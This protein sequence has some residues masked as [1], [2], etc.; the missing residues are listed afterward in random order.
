MIRD[1]PEESVKGDLP[2]PRTRLVFI[3]CPN[4]H[5]A[6]LFSA[7]LNNHSGIT[8]LGDTIPTRS[9]DVVCTC[10]EPVSRCGF[11]RGAYEAARLERYENEMFWMPRFPRLLK[12]GSHSGHPANKIANT[13]LL[14]LSLLL[15]GNLWKVRQAAAREFYENY[16]DFVDYVGK[17][18]G[19]PVFLEGRKQ[20]FLPFFIKSFSRGRVDVK[21]IHVIRNPVSFAVS[22][23]ER[24]K[25]PGG[26]KKTFLTWAREHLK[27]AAYTRL[28]LPRKN[29]LL[30]RFEDLFENPERELARIQEFMGLPPENVQ[31]P[32]AQSDAFHLIGHS[33]RNSFD[34]RVRKK[35]MST[36]KMEDADFA[37]LSKA[38]RLAGY[39][40]WK[41]GEGRAGLATGSR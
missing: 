30:V 13:L 25:I 33:T 26:Y 22:T 20:V 27:I 38:A 11:W 10:G 12:T 9:Y 7:L 21:V 6:T 40:I 1:T 29:R 18:N 37:L 5:G 2:T 39:R 15:P 16:V 36:G 24:S 17:A 32:V 31:R 34:G 23:V 3:L 4:F 19:T 28:F 35:K 14:T 8:A 41:D